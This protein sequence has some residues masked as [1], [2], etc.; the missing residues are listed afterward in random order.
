MNNFLN[1]LCFGNLFCS[2]IEQ[3][4]LVV[5][6]YYGISTITQNE[7]IYRIVKSTIKLTKYQTMIKASL[8]N[9]EKIILIYI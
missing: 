9:M 7:V 3:Y 1:N 4:V 5:A 2:Q 8:F 6:K